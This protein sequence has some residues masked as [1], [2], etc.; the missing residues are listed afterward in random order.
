MLLYNK[1]QIKEAEAP[2][3]IVIMLLRGF[4]LSKFDLALI[5]MPGHLLLG[6]KSQVKVIGQVDKVE[7]T[8]CLEDAHFLQPQ[9]NHNIK[10]DKASLAAT[11]LATLKIHA[12]ISNG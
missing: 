8:Y 9:Q 2:G 3:S 6:N 1:I 7:G 10:F 12:E 5:R 4:C 11:K